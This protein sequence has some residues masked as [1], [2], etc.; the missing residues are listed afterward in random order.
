MTNNGV[1]VITFEWADGRVA[2]IR[3]QRSGHSQFGIMLH[4]EKGFKFVDIQDPNA[5]RIE[6]MLE[7]I[8][9]SLP[10]GHSDIP[11]EE[12]LE[13]MRLIEA[14]NKSRETG[15]LVEI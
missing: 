13:V 15:K 2:T 1:D 4:R 6:G 12:M 7:A 3:G 11:A 14:A 5:S 8:L 10:K 9:R